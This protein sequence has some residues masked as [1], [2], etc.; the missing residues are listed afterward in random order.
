MND[1]SGIVNQYNWFQDRSSSGK[2]EDVD[3]L[4]VLA[5]DHTLARLGLRPWNIPR[6]EIVYTHDMLGPLTSTLYSNRSTY[7]QCVEMG[8]RG[9]VRIESMFPLGQSG[10]ILLDFETG[11]PVFDPNFFSMKPYFDT[12][13]HRPFPLF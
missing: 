2:P 3:Q 7:A 1:E 11:K 4:I 6:G 9:P 12:F 13:S 8:R 10:T 5:L